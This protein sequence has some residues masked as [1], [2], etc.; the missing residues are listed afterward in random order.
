MQRAAKVVGASKEQNLP[1]LPAT[2]PHSTAPS[3]TRAQPRE[4]RAS[5]QTMQAV[6]NMC[7]T[8]LANATKEGT[9]QRAMCACVHLSKTPQNPKFPMIDPL[10][11]PFRFPPG[12][13][14]ITPRSPHLAQHFK[15]KEA[16]AQTPAAGRIAAVR[17]PGL[18]QKPQPKKMTQPCWPPEAP[19]LPPTT[20][21]AFEQGATIPHTQFLATLST[22]H[23]FDCSVSPAPTGQHRVGSRQHVCLLSPHTEFL[24]LVGVPTWYPGTPTSQRK[25]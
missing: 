9:A 18:Q 13:P 19:T 14:R 12:V 22:P 16:C 25:K 10:P 24:F 2:H 6:C 20:P 21:R 23:L 15:Q 17:T 11:H 7:T 8:T 5:L 4:P 3:S 1:Q